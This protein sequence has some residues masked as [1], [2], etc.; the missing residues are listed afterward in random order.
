MKHFIAFYGFF[1][2]LV[3][4]TPVMRH[5]GNQS[6]TSGPVITKKED[7]IVTKAIRAKS[8]PLSSGSMISLDT[9]FRK[10]ERRS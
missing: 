8:V 5:I 3:I 2:K 1:L 10:T 7:Q 4:R 6:A 9:T